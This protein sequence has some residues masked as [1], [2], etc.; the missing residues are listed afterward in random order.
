MKSGK[1]ISIGNISKLNKEYEE[2]VGFTMN[3]KQL[4]IER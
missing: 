3:G 2:M 1:I 4:Y